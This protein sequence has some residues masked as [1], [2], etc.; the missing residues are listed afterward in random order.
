MTLCLYDQYAKAFL[1]YHLNLKGSIAY[2]AILRQVA[3]RVWVGVT[4][5]PELKLL[6]FP[7]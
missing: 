4:Q 6:H 3:L 7:G 2:Q 1:P 5:N